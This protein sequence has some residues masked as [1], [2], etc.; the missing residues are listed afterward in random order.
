MNSHRDPA[1]FPATATLL[2]EILMYIPLL[3]IVTQPFQFLGC[4]NTN[5]TSYSLVAFGRVVLT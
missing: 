5:H 4:L 3:R 2:R 1:R